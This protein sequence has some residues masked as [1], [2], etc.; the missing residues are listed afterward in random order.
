MDGSL[1]AR[2][3]CKHCG[4]PITQWPEKALDGGIA[5]VWGSTLT[6][7]WV[8]PLTGDEHEPGEYQWEDDWLNPFAA[9][10]KAQDALAAT[11]LPNKEKFI[12]TLE[13]ISAWGSEQGEDIEFW[14]ESVR[15]NRG[16]E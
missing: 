15:D 10:Q 9:I 2:Q 13:A 11:D 6:H 1:D 16:G 7:E 4:D 8:C 3:Q 5:V 14:L 12:L